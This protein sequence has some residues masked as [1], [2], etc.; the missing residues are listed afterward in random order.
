MLIHMVMVVPIA[1]PK[2]M[3]IRE[4]IQSVNFVEVLVMG[5]VVLMVLMGC[6]GMVPE[7]VNVGGVGRLLLDMDA[8]CLP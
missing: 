4:M 1:L 3:N 2:S 5:K 6:I 7:G 8:H